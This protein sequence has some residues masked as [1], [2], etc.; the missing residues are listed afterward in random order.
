MTGQ[1]MQSLA[2]G[3]IPNPGGLIFSST[4][5]HKFAIRRK[6]HRITSVST[7]M[8]CEDLYRF[9]AGDVPKTGCFVSAAADQEIFAIWGE[10]GLSNRT[11]VTRE[12]MGVLTSG[13]IPKSGGA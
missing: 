10:Y 8:P 11:R 2:C 5:N 1:N 12:D 6:C 9:T 7:S 13:E 4:R 3:N